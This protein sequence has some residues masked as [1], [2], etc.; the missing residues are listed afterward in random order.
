MRNQ[1]FRTTSEMNAKIKSGATHW[2]W[3]ETVDT[4]GNVN[5]YA[6]V[7]WGSH[8]SRNP[9]QQMIISF[10]PIPDSEQNQDTQNL[11]GQ[12]RQMHAHQVWGKKGKNYAGV[13]ARVTSHDEVELRHIADNSG[14]PLQ[15]NY[16]DQLNK[17]MSGL[18][19]GLNSLNTDNKFIRRGGGNY[20]NIITKNI[21]KDIRTILA[22]N[23]YINLKFLIPYAI[24]NLVTNESLKPENLIFEYYENIY[25]DEL[26]NTLLNATIDVNLN[27][28]NNLFSFSDGKSLYFY[29]SFNLINN[30][31]LSKYLKYKNKYLKL[32]QLHHL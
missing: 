18:N 4:N 15:D 11:S 14:K 27:E 24:K 1:Q 5:T 22:V 25:N 30:P 7:G 16:L 13:L 28:L 6:E 9:N 17:A 29:F 12:N 2:R 21:P 32:K 19:A 31:Y 26:F 23:N 8:P 10:H 3:K 20:W